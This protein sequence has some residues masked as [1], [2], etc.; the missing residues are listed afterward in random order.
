MRRDERYTAPLQQSTLQ[1]LFLHLY[2]QHLGEER[3]GEERGWS[4]LWAA[5]GLL[6]SAAPVTVSSKPHSY[7]QIAYVLAAFP[8]IFHFHPILVTFIPLTSHFLHRLFWLL[9]WFAFE[10]SRFLCVGFGGCASLPCVLLAGVSG[11]AKG[12]ASGR[13]VTC[14]VHLNLWRTGPVPHGWQLFR[15]K[16][17]VWLRYAVFFLFFLPLR[18]FLLSIPFATLHEKQN[19]TF[20]LTCKLFFVC[21]RSQRVLFGQKCQRAEINC[22]YRL[23]LF[24]AVGV[25]PYNGT[26]NR[27]WSPAISVL[28]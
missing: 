13:P 25:W 15:E 7:H 22:L 6:L 3:R 11:G 26:T 18:P 21:L 4:C 8:H 1:N 24:A 23:F 5:L 10:L 27:H 2:C 19:L 14:K 12:I 16:M 9:F 17:L 28:L 20:L